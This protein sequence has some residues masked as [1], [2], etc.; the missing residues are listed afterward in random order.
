M[1]SLGPGILS[2]MRLSVSSSSAWVATA[3]LFAGLVACSGG[4]QAS[5]TPIRLAQGG[6]PT[7]WISAIPGAAT[8]D[9]PGGW[10]RIAET[11]SPD[12]WAPTGLQGVFR[13]KVQ[14]LGIGTPPD[15][16][17]AQEL[18]SGAREL[19]YLGGSLEGI[20]LEGLQDGDHV[21]V[22]DELLLADRAG[23]LVSRELTYVAW[24][25]RSLSDSGKVQLP[26]VTSEG[27]LLGPGEVL[28]VDLPSFGPQGAT[29]H[30][31]AGAF[32]NESH[33]EASTMSL[34]VEHAG[35]VVFQVDYPKH[36][37]CLPVPLHLELPDFRGGELRFRVQGAPGILMLQNPVLTALGA[38]SVDERPDLVVFLADTFRA[39]N[40]AYGGGDPRLTPFMNEFGKGA[41]VYTGA[42]APG[43]WTIPSQAALLSGSYAPQVGIDGETFSLPKNLDTLARRLSESGYRTAAVT[44]GHFVSEHFG[45]D[46][47]FEVFLESVE[48]AEFDHKTLKRV[49]T[50]LDAD[51]ARPLFL[52]VQSYR[53]HTP[54]WVSDQSM[55]EHPE[56]F[57]EDPDPADWNFAEL[58]ERVGLGLDTRD[59]RALRAA[60]TDEQ[61]VADVDNLKRMYQGAAADLDRGF[62]SFMAQI[63]AAGMGDA[64]VVL[65]SDHG[66]AFGEHGGWVH[67]TN[68][69]EEQV[70]IPL[71]LQGPGIA[72]EL[73]G[74]PVSL[75]DVTFTLAELAGVG[76]GEH[77]VGRS[78]LGPEILDATVFSFE[79]P[80]SDK[81]NNLPEYAIYQ[82]Q[83][84][85]IGHMD[86]ERVLRE[87][88]QAFE[89]GLDP[90]E[91]KGIP[92][93]GSWGQQLIERF[94]AQLDEATKAFAKAEPK[95]I[96]QDD[97]EKFKAMGYFGD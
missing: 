5:L 48:H 81:Q 16:E 61:F 53:A 59:I 25:R 80:S 10:M 36:S 18:L 67:G 54:Y 72:H 46:Q 34:E 66:E 11:I 38:E 17:A 32:G 33:G 39:D 60:G 14:V 43:S 2:S 75:V 41:R 22:G 62:G 83:R 4:Q 63:E 28:T 85:V 88:A 70:G 13:V 20:S 69:Y 97:L 21:V 15:R 7:G 56:L 1:D 35:Q 96:S 24:H 82:G 95:P 45:F 40:L 47:G 58:F 31:A 19:R 65:T 92:A 94:A 23:G 49:Q 37:L 57:G 9:A 8:L 90:D 12:A 71:I 27:V 84:K 76:P 44:D 73:R 50:V 77:W 55:A 52:F 51:D 87:P 86:G 30:L 68:V 6:V 79:S 74:G 3:L 89:L 29:L 26:G 78:L 42:H 91:E 93:K 64:F